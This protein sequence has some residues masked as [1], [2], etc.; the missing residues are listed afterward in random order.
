MIF[1]PKQKMD[2]PI[3]NPLPPKPRWACHTFFPS[4]LA[5]G[6]DGFSY[7]ATYPNNQQ[8]WQKYGPYTD[9]CDILVSS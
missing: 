5:G 8:L 7:F 4:D 2:G 3:L 1:D 9:H 6:G